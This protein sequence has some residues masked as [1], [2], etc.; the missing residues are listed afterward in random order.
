VLKNDVLVKFDDQLLVNSKQ[1]RTLVG[2]KKEGDAVHLTYLRKGQEA[3]AEVKLATH[4]GDE[5][6]EDA[7]GLSQWLGKGWLGKIVGPIFSGAMVT[8]KD[9]NV[10]PSQ[11]TPDVSDAAKQLE[12]TLRAAGV[13]EKTIEQ[14]KKALTDAAAGIQKAAG[15]LTAAKGDIA[16]EV[17]KA[18]DQAKQAVEPAR[19]EGDVA[20]RKAAPP[21]DKA[22]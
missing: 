19:R 17:Q 7:L 22:P 4:E 13:D 10:I 14:T 1:L 2:T 5:G 8:D 12:K 15:D 21:A 16:R 20:A 18:A 11:A 6:G 3:T 9:G